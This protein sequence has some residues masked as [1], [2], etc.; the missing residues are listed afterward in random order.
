MQ[1]IQA[2]SIWNKNNF[3]IKSITNVS[4]MIIFRNKKEVTIMSF[5]WFLESSKTT[6]KKKSIF[7]EIT[8]PHSNKNYQFTPCK[9]SFRQMGKKYFP[10]VL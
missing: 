6:L 10:Y 7:I 8:Q 5:Q 2:K 3:F 9:N 1:T 4:I